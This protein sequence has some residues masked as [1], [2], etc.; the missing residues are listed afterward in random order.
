VDLRGLENIDC[1]CGYRAYEWLKNNYGHEC[2]TPICLT[3]IDR[4][5]NG[6]KTGIKYTIGVIP[7]HPKITDLDYTSGT[8]EALNEAEN[9]IAPHADYWGGRK[10]VGGSPW[11]TPSRL[12]P[13]EV[14][15]IA[16]LK[17]NNFQ[18]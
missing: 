4:W 12:T 7:L 9:K 10:T 15:D 16:L 3:I 13:E 11:N 1:R 8:F 17:H 6:V 18:P 2:Q 5:D 14:I